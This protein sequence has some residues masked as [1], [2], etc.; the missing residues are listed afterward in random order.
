[1]STFEF[2]VDPESRAKSGMVT[3]ASVQAGLSG[4]VGRG[5]VISLATY[6]APCIRSTMT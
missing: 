6:G 1:M 5:R 2:A 3:G 4:T